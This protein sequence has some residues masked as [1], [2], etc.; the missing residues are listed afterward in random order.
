M[1]RKL[2]TLAL[3]G[4][5]TFSFVGTSCGDDDDDKTEPTPVVNPDDQKKDEEKK[6]E[7]KKDEEKKDEEQ[8]DEEKKDEENKGEASTEVEGLA[9]DL[10]TMW[11]Q[12]SDVTKNDDGTVTL[13]MTEGEQSWQKGEFGFVIPADKQDGNYKK[14]VIKYKNASAKEDVGCVF[15]FDSEQVSWID[16][17]AAN[18]AKFAIVEGEEVQTLTLTPEAPADKM[19]TVRIFDFGT[20]NS[21]T[22]ISVTAAE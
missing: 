22:I 4:M 1:K 16:G 2:F 17:E 21:I 5:V 10:S 7:E 18:A 6:D 8:K 13:T 3:A 11:T 12:F 9:L 15:H 14:F 19:A 20:G